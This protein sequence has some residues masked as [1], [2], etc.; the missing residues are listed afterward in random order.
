MVR[1]RR[2]PTYLILRDIFPEWTVDLGIMRK[3]FAYGFF[4]LVAAF[5]YRL[6][7]TIGIQSPSN[8]SY[9]ETWRSRGKRLEVLNNW[10]EPAPPVGCSLRVAETRLAGRTI[11]VYVGNV[12]VAQSLEFLLDVAAV[13]R[14]RSDIGF[15][16]VGRGTAFAT[17]E[18][19]A[20]RRGLENVLFHGEIEPW[21]VAGLLEQCHVG[22]VVLDPRHRTHNVPG[23][24]LS[25][26][27]AGLPVI[28]RVNAGIDIK[29]L[30]DQEEVGAAYV[31]SSPAEF[32]SIVTGIADDAH[33]R[34][35]MAIRARAVGARMFLPSIAARQIVS[36]MSR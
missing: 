4:K 2:V 16:L 1:K 5:Q 21:E 17:L 28:A 31:G 15:L 35:A 7:D 34:Q 6:A 11:L 20:T 25:Y 12:G 14:H 24:L 3:G 18:S 33:E 36:A 27:H 32:A 29:N 10:L 23:K 19:E 13:V 22:L 26:L 8:A 9:L 30:I